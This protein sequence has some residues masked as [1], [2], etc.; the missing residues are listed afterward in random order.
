MYSLIGKS[1]LNDHLGS[2]TD[3]CYIQN[4]VITNRVIKM[5]RCNLERDVKLNKKK[6]LL[7][8]FWLYLLILWVDRS[9]KTVNTLIRL[10]LYHP[11]QTAS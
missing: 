5:L 8:Q 9:E 11:D 4:R 2:N 7:A 10:V 6:V 3:P 1:V